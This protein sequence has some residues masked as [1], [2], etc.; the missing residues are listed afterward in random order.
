MTEDYLG[1]AKIETKDSS[2]SVPTYRMPKEAVNETVMP[3]I[4]ILKE[5]NLD[6]EK[7]REDCPNV[8]PYETV[9]SCTIS[10]KKL[11]AGKYYLYEDKIFLKEKDG[12]IVIYNIVEEENK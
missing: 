2:I 10:K 11:E 1:E 8:D 4:E 12:T 7:I 5:M 6:I 3:L 9:P